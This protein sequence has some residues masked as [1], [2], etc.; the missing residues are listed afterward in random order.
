MTDLELS[1][2]RTWAEINLDELAHNFRILRSILNPSAKFLAVVKANAYGHGSIHCARK[3]QDLGADWL[4][5]A[6]IPEGIELRKNGIHIPILCL[7]QADPN[8]APLMFE[9][10]ITQAVGDFQNAKALS[11]YAQSSDR[12]INIHIKIDTGMS[13]TGFY[14]P[15]NHEG[16]DRTAR[17][18]LD[19]C[20]LPGLKAEG[21]FT[22]FA[23]ADESPEFTRL[24]L[25]RLIE[26]KDYLSRSGH[27]FGITHA[28]AS[29]GVLDYPAAHLDMGRFGLVLY[30][31]AST[32][33]GNEDSTLGLHP[34]MTLK[35]RITAVR[36][37][38]AGA[39]I[40]YGRTYTLKRDSVIAVL[41]IGYADGLHR[42]LSN[43]YGVKIR[44]AA[45]P[46][47]GRV[48]MDM[49]MI[50]VTD[51]PGGVK[52]GDVATVFDGELMPIAA[53][54]AG[55]IIHEMVCAP[56]GRVPRVYINNG[57]M[58]V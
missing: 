38:P 45:C 5:V 46:V 15:E 55:T 23:A 48:C 11:D 36:H 34:V 27:E 17:E 22:H 1:M 39:T 19:T 25:R 40:S 53:K 8:L 14:W 16:K 56:S 41:P 37:L 30:G 12:T 13:R 9:Y 35:S 29:I 47:L 58:T 57:T 50:D 44:D 31:Y 6:A 26:A 21:L 2:S 33:T 7:G 24:Q 10:N 43:N 3:L 18:I 51:I 52:A 4:A 42:V 28:A 32:E 49:T 20:N 54:N